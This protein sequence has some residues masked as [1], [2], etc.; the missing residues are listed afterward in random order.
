MSGSDIATL[1]VVGVVLAGVV[2]G[3]VLIVRRQRYIKSLR[4][5]GWT[6]VNSPTFDA[7]ARLE[8]PAVRDRLPS[9]D[10]RPDHRP[11][12]LGPGRSR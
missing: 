2:L 6:F 5:R 12:Q 10:R 7:V 8:Q 11:D 9:P 4:D 1:V 3:V